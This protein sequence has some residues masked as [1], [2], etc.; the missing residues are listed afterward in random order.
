MYELTDAARDQLTAIA[1]EGAETAL[2]AFLAGGALD[3]RNLFAARA[4]VGLGDSLERWRAATLRRY[5]P[6]TWKHSVVGLVPS[7]IFRPRDIY[8]GRGVELARRH[9][10]HNNLSVG[11]HNAINDLITDGALIKVDDGR[12]QA[13]SNGVPVDADA[14]VADLPDEGL[15]RSFV[16]AVADHVR[17]GAP[18]LAAA[19]EG[20]RIE[21]LF[22]H[23][24][25][26][27]RFVIISLLGRDRV[28]ISGLEAIAPPRSGDVAQHRPEQLFPSRGVAVS[29]AMDAA[30]L[31]LV[32]RAVRAWLL[33]D[34]DE[35]SAVRR[36]VGL[37]A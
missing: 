26:G 31:L 16:G 25:W 29:V 34:R 28:L 6:G 7:A 20:D 14:F 3:P 27:P 8:T 4:D 19:H 35:I 1:R 11:T 9:P 30:G 32:S 37:A 36:A 12:Y 23:F 2:R 22:G 21:E 24:G 5:R 15:F 13:A 10:S 18:G 33:N 17:A